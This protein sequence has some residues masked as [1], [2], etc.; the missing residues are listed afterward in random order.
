[1]RTSEEKKIFKVILGCLII[2]AL[3]VLTFIYIKYIPPIMKAV[4]IILD[5]AIIYLSYT[6]LI[7]Q[8]K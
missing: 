4:L 8:K 2:A 1:L 3:L 7:K 5:V 6:G